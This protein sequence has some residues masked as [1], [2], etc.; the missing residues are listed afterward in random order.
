VL[1]SRITLLISISL[2]IENS[3]LEDMVLTLLTVASR[4]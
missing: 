1:N 3:R 2:I 4:S